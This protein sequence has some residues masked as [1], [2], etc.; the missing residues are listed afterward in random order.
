MIEMM[1][2]IKYPTHGQRVHIQHLITRY[3]YQFQDSQLHELSSIITNILSLLVGDYNVRSSIIIDMMMLIMV[4]DTVT[5]ELGS[6][7]MSRTLSQVPLL[8]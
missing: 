5:E 1:I 3:Q 6:S 8:G 7:N 2:K 4:G